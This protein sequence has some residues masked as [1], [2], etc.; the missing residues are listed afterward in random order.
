[1]CLGLPT[2]AEDRHRQTNVL[3]HWGHPV[4]K[5]SLYVLIGIL[6]GSAYT[7]I[8]RAQARA[9]YNWAPYHS[10]VLGFPAGAGWTYG[11]FL[12]ESAIQVHIDASSP[13]AYGVIPAEWLNA[14][15]KDPGTL[16]VPANA[17]S[18]ACVGQMVYRTDPTCNLS[19]YRNGA[20]LVVLD[21][22]TAADGIFAAVETWL[23]KPD[24]ASKYAAA[25]K[26]AI[27]IDHW[28]CVANCR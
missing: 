21:E 28:A 3:N 27:V 2:W 13:V 16:L 6:V 9:V 12:R 10:E 7:A 17:R 26:V 15:K 24:D 23:G 18:M 20:Y 19:R 8:S 11:P 22:K 25:N 4:L 14:I 5:I 1:M